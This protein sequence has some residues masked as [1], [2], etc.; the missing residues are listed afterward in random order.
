MGTREPLLVVQPRSPRSNSNA[1][2][3][4]SS[5]SRGWSQ[6]VGGINIS[7]AQAVRLTLFRSSAPDLRARSSG[8]GSAPTS[9]AQ[10][11]A[12]EAGSVACPAEMGPAPSLGMEM[13]IEMELRM[14]M[15]YCP[16]GGVLG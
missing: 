15:E 2:V 7:C 4:P 6:P 3:Q 8:F 5:D 10:H 13:R 11:R 14:R 1:S 16:E 9:P 12:P